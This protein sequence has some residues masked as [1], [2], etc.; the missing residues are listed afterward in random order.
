MLPAHA[1]SRLPLT[2]P[3]GMRVLFMPVPRQGN[4]YQHELA[5][6]LAAHGV[7]VVMARGYRQPLPFLWAWLRNRPAVFHLHWT[8]PY[9]YWPGRRAPSRLLAWRLVWQLRLLRR[10]GVRIVWTVHNIATHEAVRR[11]DGVHIVPAD[12]T[13]PPPADFFVL[14]QGRIHFEGTVEEL[15]GS[16]DPFLKD[17]LAMTL[18]PW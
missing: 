5:R 4:P 11:A 14:H 9:L 13:G 15:L 10:L 1:S 3:T 6:G 7:E 16:Q 17:F 12:D 2:R 8:Q 18:P